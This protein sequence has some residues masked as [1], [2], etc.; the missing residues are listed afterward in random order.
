MAQKT[1]VAGDV[2]T[3]ADTN[4]YLSGEGGAWSTWTPTLSQSGTVTCT[5]THAKYARYGRFIVFYTALTA[6]GTG[7][8]AAAVTLSLPTAAASSGHVIPGGGLLF[9]ATANLN[10]PGVS[11][12]SSTTAVALVPTTAPG[13]GVIGI[14]EFTA[15]LANGDLIQMSGAYEAAS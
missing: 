3:A 2:V 4:T 13:N 5:V 8:G 11:Y 6:T 14:V 15:A 10:Y 12:L 9:D 1:W 7:T